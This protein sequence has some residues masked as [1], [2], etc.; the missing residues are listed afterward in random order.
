M[1]YSAA[2]DPGERIESM[3]RQCGPSLVA[4]TNMRGDPTERIPLRDAGPAEGPFSVVELDGDRVFGDVDGE[5]AVG[6]GASE[7]D[8]LSDDGDD[9]A[10]EARRLG[11]RLHRGSGWGPGICASSTRSRVA[12]ASSRQR[13]R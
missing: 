6:M 5:F 3:L 7:S 2:A 11:D 1:H 12:L 10:V 8:F 4:I 9:A 13:H